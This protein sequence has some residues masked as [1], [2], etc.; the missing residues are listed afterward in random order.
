M[1]REIKIQTEIKTRQNK[2][3]KQK[4]KNRLNLIKTQADY[5]HKEITLSLR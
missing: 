2:T 5:L 3:N 4:K 1:D